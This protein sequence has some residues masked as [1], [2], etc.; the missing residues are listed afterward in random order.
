[1]KNLIISLLLVLCSSM[2]IAQ[3]INIPA[4]STGS[5]SDKPIELKSLNI[6]VFVLE[7]I[8]TTT[9]EM[10]FYNNNNRV[11]EGELNFPLA[12][13]VTVSRYALDVNGEMR[14]GVVVEKEKATQA[15]EAITRQYV[16]PGLVEVTKGNNFKTRIY[17]IPAKGIKKT[18]IAFEQELNG[19]E[20]DFIYQLPLNFKQTLDEFSVKVEVVLNK[21]EAIKSDHPAINLHFTEIRNSF[22]SDYQEK[23]AKL[24][25]YLAFSIPKPK[26]INEVLTYKGIVSTDNYFYI[27]LNP[28]PEKRSKAKPDHIT[29]VWDVSGSAINRD[30]E[31]ELLI[32][33]DYLNWIK[34]GT[35]DLI[36][37]SNTLHTSGSFKIKDGKCPELINTLKSVSYDGGTNLGSIDFKNIQ[38]EEILFFTD[39]VSNFGEETTYNFHRPVTAINSSNIADHN[40]ME[41]FAASSNGVYIDAFSISEEDA[42]V[43][44]THEQKRFIRAEYN[45]ENI[46][47]FYPKTG[48]AITNQFS[49][50]GI[51][52]GEQNEIKL[53]FGYGNKITESHTIIVDNSKRI[54][55]SLGE[56]IWAQ[57]KLKSLLVKGNSEEIKAH[58]KKFS[59][60][61]PG[62]SLIVL[63]NV[64][65][66]VRYGIVPPESLQKEYFALVSRQTKNRETF[67]QNR[68]DQICSQF[69]EDIEWW[70]NVD[71]H[72]LIVDKSPVN[73]SIAPPPP[74]APGEINIVEDDMQQVS[75]IHFNMEMSSELEDTEV[76]GDAGYFRTAASSKSKKAE[77]E[78]RL[79][80]YSS[81]I[82]INKWESN[83]PYMSDLK[84]TDATDLYKVYL[85]LK[86]ENKENP[87]F[88]FDVATYL[89]QKSQRE[90]GLRVI[91]NLA[92]LELEDPELMRTLGRKLL[93]YNFY[94]EALAVFIEVLRTRSF[95]PHSY[96]DLGLTYAQKGEY[97]NAIDNLYIVI[98][99]D[100]DSDIISRFPGIELIV[101]HD[102]NNIIHKHGKKIDISEMNSCLIKQM[103]V[104]VRIV[105]DW[106]ANET[107]IDLWITDP[108]GEKCSYSNKTTKIGGKISNDITQG[109]GPE[110]FRLKHAVEGKY[111]IDVNFFG[112]R[113]QTL[114][115]NVT[116]RAFVYTNFGTEN[117]H[118]EVL[119]L[120]LE[121][122]KNGDFSIGEIAFKK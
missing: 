94:N 110:E 86:A 118:Q 72:R 3:T 121:P 57:K 108:T 74:P 76:S 46:K 52:E 1:M 81:S 23:D 90:D 39:G 102:I 95:E 99:K 21:P 115:G 59:L 7:N 38:S 2:L 16:D 122:N 55:N 67:R 17:P 37:F 4:I 78:G 19:N 71:D 114:L 33:K 112:S 64:Q 120:Q 77:N 35:V 101:L 83:A 47:E 106:D 62:T 31:K 68:L 79:P 28:Q 26:Q 100:W 84:A 93:E 10:D 116:V 24:D 34:S 98:N 13:G 96:I 15:F 30:L 87:S 113:K 92:E 29:V 97:Q 12:N 70:E 5:S 53:H 89:F 61:T 88:Y 73:D 56:R 117:E 50:S 104:D 75:E 45:K 27:N 119:T 49:C 11:M 82:S 42:H 32:L 44:L 91:S 66:Y 65:D 63:D 25:T 60:V 51:A 48:Q 85:K 14:E 22:I 69:K 109:Y 36:T 111:K 40:L 8:A 43:M 54:E 41:F 80:S 18:V 103:P 105:I 58:G 6:S 9:F 107:D 20:K